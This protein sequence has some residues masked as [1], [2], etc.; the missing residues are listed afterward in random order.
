VIPLISRRGFV[1]RP[2][3]FSPHANW[4]KAVAFGSVEGIYGTENLV[5]E[6]ERGFAFIIFHSADHR[7]S[8]TLIPHSTVYFQICSRNQIIE[9][10]LWGAREVRR[11]CS[12]ADHIQRAET[13]GIYGLAGAGLRV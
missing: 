1:A 3:S 13:P 11:H 6:R 4:R 9:I 10:R 2:D 8:L 5:K 12:S 7:R